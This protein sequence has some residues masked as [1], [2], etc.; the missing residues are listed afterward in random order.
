MSI[1]LI[2]TRLNFCLIPRR[3]SLDENVRAKEGG[4][5]TT[6]ETSLRLPSVYFSHGPLRFITSHSRFALAST[7]WKTKRMRRRLAEFY[8]QSFWIKITPNL[9]I[10]ARM[11]W[12]ISEIL[13]P[14]KKT[15]NRVLSGVETLG[16]ASSFKP[17]NALLLVSQGRFTWKWR[18]SGKWGNT[19]SWGSPPIHIIS[20][21]VSPL[22]MRLYG[23]AGYPT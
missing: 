8:V 21:M 12:S 15:G 6:G 3:L 19:L 17:Y 18:T 13:K 16:Y 2:R 9:N 1:Y 11:S 4:K 22:K 23:Q 10:S 7:M 20:Y 14:S 5:E